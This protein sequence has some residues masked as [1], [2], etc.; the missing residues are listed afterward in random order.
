M[1]LLTDDAKSIELDIFRLSNDRL[2]E[3]DYE[4][5]NEPQFDNYISYNQKF[6]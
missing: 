2:I 3:Y 5:V 4:V 6:I 1:V